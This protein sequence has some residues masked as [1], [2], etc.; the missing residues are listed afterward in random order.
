MVNMGSVNK[1]QDMAF[2]GVQNNIQV[3]KC[4]EALETKNH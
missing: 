1:Q 4:F 3:K 2:A